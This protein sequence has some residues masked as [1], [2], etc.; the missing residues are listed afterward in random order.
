[1]IANHRSEA[2]WSVMKRQP[3]LLRGLQRAGFGGGW[4]G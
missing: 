1:M 3:A 4:F 2:V